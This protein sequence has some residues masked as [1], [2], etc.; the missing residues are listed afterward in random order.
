MAIIEA[1]I[2]DD[3]LM[4]ELGRR[5]HK[6]EEIDARKVARGCPE[7]DR[8]SREMMKPSMGEREIVE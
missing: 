1:V 2:S 7:R 6:T 4:I 3:F 5:R 8:Q